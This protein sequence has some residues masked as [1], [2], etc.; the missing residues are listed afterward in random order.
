MNNARSLLVLGRNRFQIVS[1]SNFQIFAFFPLSAALKYR[2]PPLLFFSKAKAVWKNLF[3][4][5]F[6]F[7][8]L[9]IFKLSLTFLFPLLQH[10]GRIL[11]HILIQFSG[12]R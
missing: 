8:N 11:L 5:I 7:S 3:I 1:S 2:D 10:R 6:K 9:Q 12:S 4:Q